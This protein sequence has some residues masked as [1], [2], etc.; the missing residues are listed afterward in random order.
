MQIALRCN[1]RASRLLCSNPAL[2][3]LHILNCP[4]PVSVSYCTAKACSTVP[5]NR[6]ALMVA[7]GTLPVQSEWYY[8]H[9]VAKGL[10]LVVNIMF[11]DP[12]AAVNVTVDF[13]SDAMDPSAFDGVFTLILQLQRP[14]S[15]Y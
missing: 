6:Y 13:G 14:D 4:A 11:L 9:D 3:Q 8:S 12:A 7:R 5:F 15:A 2:P 10:G 1:A